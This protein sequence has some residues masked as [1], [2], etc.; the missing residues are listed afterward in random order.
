MPISAPSIRQEGSSSTA[1]ARST[2]AGMETTADG[3]VM[4]S[5]RI[6]SS[7]SITDR[8]SMIEKT[9]AKATAVPVTPKRTPARTHSAALEASTSG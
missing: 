5:G 9:M 1:R 2:I 6:D 8:A 4:R 3:S 7:M